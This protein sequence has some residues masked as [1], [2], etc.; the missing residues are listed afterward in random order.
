MELDDMKRAWQEL[1][2]RLETV[3]VTNAHLLREAAF[4]KSRPGFRRLSVLLL[5]ELILGL[6]APLLVGGFLADHFL[7]ARF[8]IPA[9]ALQVFAVWMVV[10]TARQLAMVARLDYAAP[11]VA[12]QQTLAE[13][14]ASRVRMSRA[15]L[16]LSPLLWPPLAVVAAKGCFGFDL[17]RSFG[18]LW[19]ASNL[20]FGLAVIPIAL[21]I[22]SRLA[23][24]QTGSRFLKK[25]ADQLAGRTLVEAQSRIAEISRFEQGF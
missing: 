20:A 5:F 6:A 18:A 3:E 1:N 15:I 23:K 21:L 17:Y 8:A 10:T 19:V 16:L 13:L 25:L 22:S 9:F 12:I 14:Y 24:S 2:N 11:V 4:D 7:E